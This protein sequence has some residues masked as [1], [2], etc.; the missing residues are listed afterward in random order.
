MNGGLKMKKSIS[1]ILS[2]LLVLALALTLF[3]CGKTGDT[4]ETTGDVDMPV[5]YTHLTLPTTPYV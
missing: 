1:A 2:V 3:S 4:D 5:S